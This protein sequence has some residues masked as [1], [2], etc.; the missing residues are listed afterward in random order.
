MTKSIT[1]VGVRDAIKDILDMATKAVEAVNKISDAF[2]K[3]GTI[4]LGI[5][6]T[7]FIK[8]MAN[9]GKIDFTKFTVLP[10]LFSGIGSAFNILSLQ[11][12]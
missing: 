3:F 8:Q 9:F 1:T 11:M 6:I 2:G 7:S 10:N 4:G 12:E 5:G